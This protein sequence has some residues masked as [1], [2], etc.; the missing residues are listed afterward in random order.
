MLNEFMAVALEGGGQTLFSY[1]S[2]LFDSYQVGFLRTKN[3]FIP[4]P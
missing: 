4:K 1:Q 3:V 2:E